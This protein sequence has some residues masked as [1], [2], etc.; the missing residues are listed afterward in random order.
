MGDGTQIN[1]Y[2]NKFRGENLLTSKLLA[3]LSYDEADDLVK[4]LSAE[5]HGKSGTL[6]ARFGGGK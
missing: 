1:L 3:T 2:A 5:I 6:I 4:K